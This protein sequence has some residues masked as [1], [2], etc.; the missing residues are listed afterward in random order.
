MSKRRAFLSTG[1]LKRSPKPKPSA[2]AMATALGMRRFDASLSDEQVRIIARAID[3]ATKLA[4]ELNTGKNRLRNSDEPV[5]T[6]S[7]ELP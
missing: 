5:T 6:F 7:A 4:T 2:A 1:G 3:E